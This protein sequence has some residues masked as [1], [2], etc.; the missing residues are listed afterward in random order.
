VNTLSQ[1]VLSTNEVQVPMTVQAP[2]SPDPTGDVVQFAFTPLTYPVTQP[3]DEDWVDGSWVV[4]PGP[5]YWAQCTV[6]PAN[7]GVALAIG[8][9]TGWTKVI[10]N[11]AVPVEQTFLVEITL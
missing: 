5:A 9:W 7:G 8:T 4:F 11:P 1:S 3:A 2:G 10:D 6:G